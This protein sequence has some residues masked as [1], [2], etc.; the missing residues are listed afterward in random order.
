MQKETAPKCFSC[1]LLLF[2]IIIIII[3][4][5]IAA[6]VCVYAHM[7]LRNQKHHEIVLPT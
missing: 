1:F 3:I 2:L 6:V 4:I 7:L 5:V